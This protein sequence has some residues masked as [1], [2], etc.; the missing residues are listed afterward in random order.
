M[1]SKGQATREKIIGAARHLFKYQGYRNTTIDDI[2]EAS[3]VKRGNL[4]FYFKSK[5]ELALVAI[6][7]ALKREFPFLERI[8]AGEFDP[9]TK[10]D[11]MID[12]MVDYIIARD[13][14]G[15]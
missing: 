15:G 9:L 14:R 6:D 13:C 12:G 5:E 8:M 2:C 1:G 4:Y 3:H 11:L 10:V 7:D